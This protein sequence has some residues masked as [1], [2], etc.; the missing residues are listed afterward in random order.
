MFLL[1][2]A[3]ALQTQNSRN[4]GVGRY[5]RALI[6]QIH[7]MYPDWQI[8][9]VENTHLPAII[10]E[11]RSQFSIRR[12][13]PP[14][15]SGYQFPAN[16]EL[17]ELY[18]ADWLCSQAADVCLF[19][20]VFE[21][22]AVV[23]CFTEVR[24]PKTAAI[25]YDLIPL[26][27][28]QEYL[29]RPDDAALYAHRFR[30]LCQMDLL[31]AI[32][33]STR[34]DFL[35][36]EI[37]NA[38]QV[39]NIRGATSGDFTLPSA[40]EDARRKLR[41]LDLQEDFILYVGG[42]DYRKNMRGAIEAY[43]LLP[44][45]VQ[46]RHH[47]VITCGF[48]GNHKRQYAE[49]IAEAG[50]TETVQLTDW[51]S[52]EELHALYQTCRLFFFPS[53]YEGLGLPVLEALQSGAPVVC[54]NNSSLPEYGGQLSYLADPHSPQQMSQ[55]L[56]QALA[57]PRDKSL[58][59]RLEFTRQFTWH[60]TAQRAA[61]AITQP[62]TASRL[63]PKRPR[64]AWVSPL[65]P[66]SSPVANYSEDLLG[67]LSEQFE[68]ELIVDSA[69]PEMTSNFAD[70]FLVVSDGEVGD[71]HKANPY[72]L[73]IYH[74]G[75]HPFH[76]Y[77]LPLLQKYR[78]LVVLHDYF[79]GDLVHSAIDRGSWGL[80]LEQT[81]HHEGH[82]EL[83]NLLVSGQISPQ[84]VNQLSPL[85]HRILQLADSVV[86]HSRWAWQRVKANSTCPVNFIPQYSGPFHK[87]RPLQEVR[88][89]LEIAKDAFVIAS[90]GVHGQVGRVDTLLEAAAGLPSDL[91]RQCHV[92]IAG[93]PSPPQAT[94]FLELPPALTIHFVDELSV[95]DLGILAAA[96]DVCV[97]LH[98][99]TRSAISPELLVAMGSE[100][101]CVVST[102]AKA[103]EFPEGT[104]W[105]IRAAQHEVN[106]LRDML[107][108]IN[109]HPKLTE[110]VRMAAGEFIRGNHS[111]DHFLPQFEFT[112]SQT[113]ARRR[114]HDQS[115]FD[116]I[117]AC[118]ADSQIVLPDDLAQNWSLLREN[119]MR[120][121]KTAPCSPSAIESPSEQTNRKKSA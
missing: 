88:E 36:L 58:E 65:P 108:F 117:T 105:E 32:S 69:A 60:E 68:I 81:L 72:D 85:N 113:L 4:R 96:A 99:P 20:N 106:D 24:P 61:K 9:L 70:R 119:V 39:V 79:L 10:A 59:K 3:Q 35:D 11:V 46:Q 6:C 64:L 27:F 84:L 28:D 63:K 56:Q 13:T 2:D 21:H 16:R 75:N 93:S 44:K 8:E 97:Q 104:I 25:L 47:L 118:I 101:N 50:L 67:Q 66:L 54:S 116:R 29:C 110:Q 78:G 43:A 94:C 1:I 31:L 62:A 40:D 51:V 103:S 14:L 112:V 114:E 76:G 48:H 42:C 52:E 45:G 77:M 86:V 55:S 30:Q 82:V 18:Y 23:P 87:N 37:I 15:A 17:N 33:Q 34:K 107:L 90:L 80:S 121:S 109:N 83:A 71:R 102:T 53:F 22:E 19:C 115:W 98:N 26:L 100:A 41:R 7:S 92:I 12:F 49:L 5:A 95:E 38:P 111:F 120:V 89:R 57:E 74:L 73:F 91:R